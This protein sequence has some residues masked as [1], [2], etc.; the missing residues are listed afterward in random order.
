MGEW[1][2]LQVT[3]RAEKGDQVQEREARGIQE[4][5]K[6]SVPNLD[7]QS[8]CKDAHKK[9]PQLIEAAFLVPPLAIAQGLFVRWGGPR[10]AEHSCDKVSIS[11]VSYRQTA[12]GL[13]CT[14]A[15]P[16]LC[17]HQVGGFNVAV[18]DVATVKQATKVNAK[19]SPKRRSGAP[20]TAA[21]PLE[22]RLGLCQRVQVPNI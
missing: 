5:P 12:Y 6:S 2:R 18:D 4:F 15:P 7:P 11:A 10:L 8:Y 21:R 19:G 16:I 1:T 9:D 22:L 17:Q 13:A 14:P 20:G 3:R